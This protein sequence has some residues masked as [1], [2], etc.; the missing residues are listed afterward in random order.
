M[1]KDRLFTL[2]HFGAGSYWASPT[3]RDRL[4]LPFSESND[5]SL[6]CS[7]HQW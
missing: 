2:H 1:A 5:L 6:F 4:H 7:H 3:T